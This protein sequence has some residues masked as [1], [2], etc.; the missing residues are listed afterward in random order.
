MSSFKLLGE[1]YCRGPM[2][3]A[4]PG[5]LWGRGV[6]GRNTDSLASRSQCEEACADV[7]A[8]CSAY[9]WGPCFSGYDPNCRRGAHNCALYGGQLEYNIPTL[10]NWTGIP[11]W[12][13]HT[14][15]DGATHR[16]HAHPEST[17]GSVQNEHDGNLCYL[18]CHGPCPAPPGP[19]PIGHNVEDSAFGWG[20]V[21]LAAIV[22]VL[23]SAAAMML[24]AKF[25]VIEVSVP[26]E[27]PL[28]SAAAAG[29]LRNQDDASDERNPAGGTS[30]D[31]E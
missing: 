23:L 1:G 19:P 28:L 16:S 8:Q 20:S 11:E 7:G 31:T 2:A 25:R 6:M 22:G 4:Q 17:V 13:N 3:S 5:R 26:L 12:L 24:A 14:T 27:S 15:P 9:G 29:G 10:G 21:L 30:L 18:N